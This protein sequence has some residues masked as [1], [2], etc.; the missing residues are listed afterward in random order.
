MKPDQAKILKLFVFLLV[1]TGLSIVYDYPAT[2]MKRPQ[3]VHNWR[4]CDGASL[5]LSY[6]QNGM[7]F[8]KPQT[9]GL[10][11]DGFTTGYTAP[12]EIPVLYFF[13]AV[14]YKIFGYHEF[15]F[16]LVN[17]LLFF[18]GL[19]YLFKL[20]S[21]ILNDL[22]Y[23]VIVVVLIFSSP[24]L[25]FYA[26][27][28]V[29]NTVAL[30]F[31]FIGWY[32]FYRFYRNKQNKSFLVSMLFFGIAGAMKITELTGPII[33]LALISAD[34]LKI[35]NVQLNSDGRFWLR[36]SAIAFIFTV[37]AGWALY[38]RY[39]NNLHGSTLFSTFTFPIWE[40]TREDIR[41]TF[42]KMN[43]LW[44]RD[45]FYPATFYFMLASLLIMFIS[46]KR[47]DKM[48]LFVSGLLV[49]G[50]I[51][52]A[53]LW[54]QALGDH[55]YFF[56]GFYVLPAFAFINFFVILKKIEFPG[57]S[58]WI[59]QGVFVV[60]VIVNVYNARERHQT[61]YHS[62]MNEYYKNKDIYSI[63]PYL[64]QLGIL[65]TDAVIS[66]PDHSNVSLYLMN[67]IGWTEY[68][69][70]RFIRG[71]P[72]Y[73]NRDS[74]GIRNSI[75]N[76]AKYLIINGIEELYKKA[77]LKDYCKNLAGQYKNVLIFD[78]KRATHNF[79]L[80]E[81][82]VKK[83]YSCDAENL[84]VDQGSFISDSNDAY[85]FRN[86][87]NQSDDFAHNGRYSSKIS[88]RSPYGMT[89]KFN[90]VKDGESFAISVWRKTNGKPAGGVVASANTPIPYYNGE[91]KI[92]QTDREGWE[93][94]YMEFFVT[95]E[96]VNQEL[97]IY[98]YNP[99]RDPAY[100]DD[101]HIIRYESV[102]FDQNQ[103]LVKNNH[104]SF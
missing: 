32:Y 92:I 48:L 94:L 51:A 18:L 67:Q 69:Y 80:R 7:Q 93:K 54:F 62:W 72:V 8:F 78:L 73:F 31:S 57:V 53:M 81:R 91:Y 14:L 42:H 99:Y 56:T 13:V 101:M 33:V 38:A 65:P 52:F 2:L 97:L 70:R 104:Y 46:G 9:H 10:Y 76:G 39:Y 66:I 16:R 19:F 79:N 102:L 49:I 1:I 45:Y 84:T 22:F 61:R 90:D 60:V 86:G 68:T 59:M 75:D 77:F 20:A 98:L 103:A 6:Y 36:F 95:S 30:S 41:V 43:V 100:F 64:R 71:E 55:D 87:E 40:M 5:A 26:N 37:V 83:V 88:E 89:I 28:F 58:R 12:S 11:S 17:L 47:S 44:F 25:V 3:S 15:I 21:A 74:A 29:P 63:T 4:Q 24:L 50:L 82:T 96:L 35:Y 23:P 34:K 85:L 27:N